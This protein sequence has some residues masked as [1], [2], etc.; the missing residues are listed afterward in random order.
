MVLEQAGLPVPQA[1]TLA[2]LALGGIR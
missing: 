1:D 2:L